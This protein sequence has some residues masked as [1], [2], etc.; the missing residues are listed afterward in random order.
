MAA[1]AICVNFVLTILYHVSNYRLLGASDFY[2]SQILL[3]V[4]VILLAEYLYMKIFIG[5][6]PFTQEIY[7]TCNRIPNIQ[8]QEIYHTSNRDHTPSTIL[9]SLQVHKSFNKSGIPHHVT[10]SIS[11]NIVIKPS[12]IIY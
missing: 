3:K 12:A 8:R 5:S 9:N 7:H 11:D 1:T 4:Q 10:S 6:K 2:F